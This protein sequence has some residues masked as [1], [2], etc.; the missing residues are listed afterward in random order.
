MG[1]VEVERGAFVGGG[2]VLLPGV[3]VGANAVVGAGSVVASDVP[4]HVVAAGNPVRILRET[5]GY[6]EVGV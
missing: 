3:R 1:H 6:N 2:A 4:P 5:K